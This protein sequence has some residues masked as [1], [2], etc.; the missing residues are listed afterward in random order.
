MP[1]DGGQDVTDGPVPSI[2]DDTVGPARR[3]SRNIGIQTGTVS[4]INE[5]F[6]QQIMGCLGV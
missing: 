5:V 6:S 2:Y 3:E 4:R 1:V